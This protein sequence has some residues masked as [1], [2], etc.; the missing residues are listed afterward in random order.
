MPRIVHPRRHLV[1]HRAIA[2]REEL[3]RQHPDI[4]ELLGDRA[5]ER[6]TASAACSAITPRAGT[7]E[8]REDAVVVDVLGRVPGSD[9]AVRARARAAP[10]IRARSRRALDDRGHAARKPRRL[11]ECGPGG[12]R[13][14]GA[15]DPDLPLAVIA[16]QRSSSGSPARRSRASAAVQLLRAGDLAI[17][18]GPAAERGRPAPSRRAGTCAIVERAGPAAA[19]APG[20]TDRRPRADRYSRTHRSRRRCVRQIRAARS[21]SS[22]VGLRPFGGDLGRGAARLGRVDMG[23]IAELRR[24]HRQHPPEL[25]AA[26]DADRRSRRKSFGASATPAVCAARHA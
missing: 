24:R 13:V 11:A 17:R 4:V 19:P 9:R 26:Q 16:E 10:R 18:R 2:R 15:V 6:R 20:R 8:R 12:V 14:V 21:A 25:S 7:V 5:R 22:I 3:R 1:E 23:A